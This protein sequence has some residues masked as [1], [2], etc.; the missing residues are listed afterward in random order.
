MTKIRQAPR[1]TCLP[2][3][4]SLIQLL[5]A[6]QHPIDFWMDELLCEQKMP[7]DARHHLAPAF[8]F[9]FWILLTQQTGVGCLDSVSQEKRN[10]LPVCQHNPHKCHSYT[11][12]GKREHLVMV[13]LQ[14]HLNPCA[15]VAC[16]T[17]ATSGY[18]Y[19]HVDTLDLVVWVKGVSDQLPRDFVN[20]TL[21]GEICS[22][23]DFG[24]MMETIY[25]YDVDENAIRQSH[26]TKYHTEL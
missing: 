20:L 15:S 21:L 11:T 24:E 13:G 22:Y 4:P 18:A 1:T 26:Q 12:L 3:F 2:L 16:V 8:G 17:Y 5:P 19:Q 14:P 10:C 9:L 23:L 6:N 7:L 25:N